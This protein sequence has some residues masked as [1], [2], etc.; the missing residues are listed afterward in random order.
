MAASAI[1]RYSLDAQCLGKAPQTM[2]AQHARNVALTTDLG[3]WVDDLVRS[4]EYDSASEV[5]QDA[6]QALKERRERDA[7]ELQQIRDRLRKGAAQADAG[8]YAPGTGEDA[9][10]RAF[11]TGLKRAHM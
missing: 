10:R 8:E 6:L 3:S 2:M 9:V 5:V 1:R 11:E 4:G 7:A